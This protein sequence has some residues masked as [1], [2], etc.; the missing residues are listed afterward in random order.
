MADKAD[1]EEASCAANNGQ[2]PNPSKKNS[3]A[4]QQAKAQLSSVGHQLSSLD[5]SLRHDYFKNQL[6]AAGV[7]CVYGMATGEAVETPAIGTPAAVGNCAVGALGGV[8]VNNVQYIIT[9]LGPMGTEMSMMGQEA[10]AI[11]NV[12]SA[13]Y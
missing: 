10:K 5:S 6:A 1:S 11:A 2:P 13:C 4:C 3:P 9:N 8:A 7:G 12:I